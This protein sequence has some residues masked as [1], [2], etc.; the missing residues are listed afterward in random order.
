[1]TLRVKIFQ[2]TFFASNFFTTVA[3]IKIIVKWLSGIS[4]KTSFIREERN[5]S[6]ALSEKMFNKIL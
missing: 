4:R 6:R 1:M 3:I 5:G 2:V